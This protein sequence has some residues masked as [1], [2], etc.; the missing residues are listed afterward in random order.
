MSCNVPDMEC[1]RSR[2]NR[3]V[4]QVSGDLDNSY[5]TW[6]RQVIRQLEYM[7]CQWRPQ[8]QLTMLIRHG[9]HLTPLWIVAHLTIIIGESDRVRYIRMNTRQER[10]P[11]RSLS[12]PLLSILLKLYDQYSSF[13][14]WPFTLSTAAAV[15]SLQFRFAILLFFFQHLIISKT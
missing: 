4:I 14:V 3:D 2:P 15:Q 1:Q 6:I 12:I 5:R 10:A 9:C 8:M 7:S 11:F 13:G